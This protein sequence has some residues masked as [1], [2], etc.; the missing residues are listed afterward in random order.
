[1]DPILGVHPPQD[2]PRDTHKGFSSS[3]KHVDWLGKLPR[4]LKHPVE[5][6]EVNQ[7]STTKNHILLNPGWTISLILLSS[8]LVLTFPGKLSWNTP[9]SPLTRCI[10]PSLPLR[11]HCT[12]HPETWGIQGRSHPDE[13][14][15]R[16]V[17]AYKIASQTKHTAKLLLLRFLN[18]LQ[19]N[20]AKRTAFKWQVTRWWVAI[21]QVRW[22]EKQGHCSAQPVW[23]QTHVEIQARHTQE[24]ERGMHQEEGWVLETLSL[25]LN[26]YQESIVKA[27]WLSIIWG[28]ARACQWGQGTGGKGF[29]LWHMEGGMDWVRQGQPHSGW[30]YNLFEGKGSKPRKATESK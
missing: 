27:G 2:I 13:R 12:Q 29:K 1:M 8:N 20:M 7:Y 19:R 26:I 14:E 17:K 28:E 5:G 23:K 30:T 9:S 16:W 21:M 24:Q 11:R 3:T 10:L 4:T 22:Q 6:R 18:K 15:P 25:V